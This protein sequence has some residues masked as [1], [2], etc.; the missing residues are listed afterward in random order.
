MSGTGVGVSGTG[1]EVGTGVSGTGVN[2][3]EGVGVVKQ[4]N[5]NTP[6]SGAKSAISSRRFV[7]IKA[8][9]SP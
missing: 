4:S 3:A 9:V 7:G 6:S 2:V 8:L 5:V 1:V